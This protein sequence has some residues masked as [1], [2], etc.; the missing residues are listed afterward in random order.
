VAEAVV[1]EVIVRNLDDQLRLQ[2]A[3]PFA[4]ARAVNQAQPVALSL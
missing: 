3:K 2:G 1:G 4:S